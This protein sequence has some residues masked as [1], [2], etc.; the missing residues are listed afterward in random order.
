MSDVSQPL[1]PPREFEEQNPASTPV[2]AGRAMLAD[3]GIILS[4]VLA[5]D[6]LLYRTST[7]LGWGIFFIGAPVFLYVAKRSK[8]HFVSS[9]TAAVLL[10]CIGI[11]IIWCGSWLQV[12]CGSGLV[13]AYA[14]ALSG[15]PPFLPE[16]F[17]FFAFAMAGTAKRISCFRFGTVNEATGAVKP[18]LGLP[19]VLPLAVVFAFGSLFVLANPNISNFVSLQLQSLSNHAYALFVDIQAGEAVFWIL[20]GWLVLGMLYPAGRWLLREEPPTTVLQPL[21]ESHL[22]APY[23]NTLLSV[24]ALFI[25]YLGFEFSTLWFREFPEDFYY[26]GYA[27]Q[28]AF[29]LTVAL[30]VSTCTLSCI[31]NG[32]TLRDP[33]LSKLKRLAMFWSVLNILLAIAVFHRLNIYVQFN[34]LTQMRIIGLLGIASV[35]CGFA[36]VVYKVIR[37]KDFVWLVHRQLWVP[38]LATVLFAILPVD[39]FV[40][41]YNTNQ[42]LKGETP[43]IVQVISH[44]ATPEGALAIFPLLQHEQPEIHNGVRALLAVWAVE[45]KMEEGEDSQNGFTRS[46]WISHLGHHTPWVN[47]N[48]GFSQLDHESEAKW[49]NYQLATEVL[50]TKLSDTRA[51]WVPYLDRSTREDALNAFFKYAY[52]WY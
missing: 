34:G 49:K 42:V 9:L 8:V 26:A 17:S 22:Y 44:K 2:V 18:F 38:V 50:R 31:F 37:N 21:Q 13:L 14:M 30:A 33:R 28:G 25:A 24:I 4:W 1:S 7:F 52:Q 35:S 47:L 5:T 27:H 45:L 23:R 15:A 20:S 43:A 16:I 19:V 36:L 39:W 11:K 48:E 51:D 12:A 46:P 10:L 40:N 41:R 3:I 32:S 6:F 29:W